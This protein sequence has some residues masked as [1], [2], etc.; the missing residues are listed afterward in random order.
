MAKKQPVKA[1]TKAKPQKARR[2][3]RRVAKPKPL[4]RF[5]RKDIRKPEDTNATPADV[6]QALTSAKGSLELKGKLNLSRDSIVVAEKVFQWRLLATDVAN[7]EDHIL[8]M[9][10]A[11]VDSNKPLN[12]ILVFPV[13]DKFYV[14]DGHHRL[15]AYHTA[16]WIAPIPATVFSGTLDEAYLEALKVNSRNKLSMTKDDKHEAAWR[17]VKLGV[18]SK[19]QIREVT[20]V[21]TSTV[22]NMR[23]VLRKLLEL[24]RPEGAIAIAVLTWKRALREDYYA[25]EDGGKKW[26]A[27]EWM[28]REANKIVEALM[29]ANIGFMLRKQP[30]ITAMALERLDPNLPAFLMR[31]WLHWPENE[32][33]IV[34]LIRDHLDEEAATAWTVSHEPKMF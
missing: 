28:E 23:R 10:N 14:V 2:V 13:G 12:A 4:K 1:K 26:D 5:V 19:A 30:E 17:L 20:T 27:D 9:A 8:S 33:Y 16:S 34:G 31:E 32:E 11:I 21:A 22:A 3:G 7:R 18:L 6:Q 25:P 29:K 24:K 15:A